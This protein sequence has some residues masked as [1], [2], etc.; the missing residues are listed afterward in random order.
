M[1]TGPSYT[2]KR[3][4][5]LFFEVTLSKNDVNYLH[6]HQLPT[7][8]IFYEPES[9][10]SGWLDVTGHLRN[11]QGLLEKES[12]KLSLRCDDK[13]FNLQTFQKEFKQIFHNYR[14]EVD[15]SHFVELM[16]SQDPDKKYLG[17]L[18]LMTQPKH[19]FSEI[20]CF[21]LI[22]HLFDQHDELR[23]AVSDALSRYLAHPEVGYSPPGHI[24]E[25]VKRAVWQMSS[26]SVVGLLKTA[27]LDEENLMTRGSIGQSVG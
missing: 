21:M 7:A 8:V 16:A 2:K 26:V 15:R 24:R 23:F 27:L 18:G 12:I 11:D 10:L 9:N 17:F 22:N 20:T 19:R 3:K 13:P 1:K 25:Y 4:S 14:I 5:G 6:I